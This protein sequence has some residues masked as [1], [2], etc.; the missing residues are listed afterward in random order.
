MI[1]VSLS[2]RIPAIT[3]FYNEK[4]LANIKKGKV[5]PLQARCGSEGA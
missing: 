1:N 5:F 4:H 3:I 2:G